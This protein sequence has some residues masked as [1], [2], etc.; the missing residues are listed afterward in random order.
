MLPSS[1]KMP[2]PVASSSSKSSSARLGR[3]AFGCG[4]F[5]FFG[6]TGLRFAGVGNRPSHEE[7]S[8]NVKER[9]AACLGL[10]S[11][12]ADNLFNPLLP[13]AF[14][15]APGVHLGGLGSARAGGRGLD[16]ESLQEF[17]E[18]GAGAVRWCYGRGRRWLKAWP[19]LP[20][21]CRVIYV[22][23]PLV[24]V[25]RDNAWHYF[26]KRKATLAASGFKE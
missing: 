6:T 19:R 18:F 20:R 24:A 13:A 12:H 25:L 21:I 7:P 3:W 14:V 8:G 4:C 15:A 1:S 22:D 10:F 9:Q 2:R 26:G 16:A 17:G 11:H 23:R 5:G